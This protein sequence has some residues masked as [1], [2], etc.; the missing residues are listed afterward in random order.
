[1]GMKRSSPFPNALR[2][3]PRLGPRR[4]LELAAILQDRGSGSV[5]IANYEGYDFPMVVQAPAPIADMVDPHPQGTFCDSPA[6]LEQWG[7]NV[8]LAQAVEFAA[9]EAQA[10]EGERNWP[11]DVLDPARSI[12]ARHVFSAL[13]RSL[14]ASL[15]RDPGLQG[16]EAIWRLGGY[17]SLLA[18]A[19]ER[20]AT[21]LA[22]VPR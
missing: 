7:I 9:R 17:Q 19:H 16:I 21:I 13:R 15:R 8:D 2:S 5:A 12:S 11:S 4:S 14:L 1:M 6:A 20:A 22:E 18:L 3:D 10:V